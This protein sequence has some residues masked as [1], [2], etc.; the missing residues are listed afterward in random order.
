[1]AQDVTSSNPLSQGLAWLTIWV[2]LLIGASWRQSSRLAVAF[3]YLIL[4]AVIFDTYSHHT[5]FDNFASV[6]SDALKGKFPVGGDGST[7]GTKTEPKLA[8]PKYN[9]RPN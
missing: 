9:P 3:S 2:A 8:P 1:M 5:F 7:K 6:W 4:I